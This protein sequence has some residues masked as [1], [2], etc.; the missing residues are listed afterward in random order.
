[1]TRIALDHRVLRHDAQAH[2]GVVAGT[3]ARPGRPLRLVEQGHHEIGLPDRV[4]ALQHDE[5]ALEA[6]A[7]VDAGLRERH[8][9]PARQLVVLHEHEVPDLGVA[10]VAAERGTAR[11]A[12]AVT[13]VVEDLGARTAGARLAHAPEVGLVE[14]LDAVHGDANRVVP[15]GRGLVVGDVDRDPEPVSLEPEDLGV[16]LPRV[17]DGELFEVVAEA[18]VAEHLEEDEVTGGAPDVV[19]VVVLAARPDA[20]LRRRRPLERRHLVAGEVRLERDHA[21][22]REQHGRV[23]RDDARRGHDRVTAFREEAGEGAAQFVRGHGLRHG[24]TSLPAAV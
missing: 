4:D 9:L 13:E 10:L 1:M 8:H 24:L 15:D 5:V 20:L 21:R 19:E 22:D 11:R 18:E 3:D 14:A 7:G 2:V 6:R 23:V 12:E 16:E 17:R